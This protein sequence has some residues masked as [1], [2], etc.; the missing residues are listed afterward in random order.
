MQTRAECVPC[1]LG[2]ILNM[3]DFVELPAERA[4]A[5]QQDALARL[6]ALDLRSAT[7]A[8]LATA[9]IRAGAQAAGSAD[10]YLEAKRRYNRVALELLPKL[11]PKV[12][13][14]PEGSP[15][16]L[17]RALLIAAAGNIIDFG[18]FKEVDVE[19][20][21]DQV[22]AR[23]FQH[24]DLDLLLKRLAGARRI[25]YLA[26]NAGEIVLDRFAVAELARRAPVTVAVK[27][28]PILNDALVED[29]LAAGLQ[30]WAEIT[31]TGQGVL[32]VTREASPGFWS[33]FR[34]A[35]VVLSKGHANF[36]SLDDQAHPGLFFL[37]TVKC[38]VVGDVLGCS[39]GDVVLKAAG[40][41]GSGARCPKGE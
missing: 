9:C 39:V 31:T 17:E 22:L 20:R 37:L 6:A 4:L 18:I 19:S 41:P 11:A 25:L 35:G 34:A 21:V 23:G 5:A 12:E 2:Q 33:A 8:M 38:Q 24:S 16:R 1:T 13:R 28:A 14:F 40:T 26:D 36:E 29:A 27:G 10:P 32:G 7:P 3:R 15:E 30:E